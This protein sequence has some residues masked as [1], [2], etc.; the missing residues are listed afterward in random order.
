VESF[1]LPADCFILKVPQHVLT[2]YQ[3]VVA[4]F[5]VFTI[6]PDT[7]AF[8]ADTTEKSWGSAT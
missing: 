8:A 5:Q 7:H 3:I 4:H 1:R 2:I 6:S